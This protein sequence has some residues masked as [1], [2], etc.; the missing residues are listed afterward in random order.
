L[1]Y[2]RK[3]KTTDVLVF[4]ITEPQ[5]S[6]RMFADIVISVD[7]AI[8][9]AKIFKTTPLYE[10]KLYLIHGALHLLG[11]DD[12]GLKQRQLMRKKEKTYVNT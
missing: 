10:I 9:N 2:L 8:R 11:Y 1:K 5:D 6:K 4:D 12:H 3:G 7:T